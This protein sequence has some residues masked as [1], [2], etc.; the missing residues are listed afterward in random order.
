M[1]RIDTLTGVRGVAALW[2]L[3]HHAATAYLPDRA[4]YQVLAK[5]AA[6]GWLGVD[7][8]FVLSGFVIS[9]VYCAALRRREPGA[10]A[11]FLKLRIARVYPAQVVTTL[12]LVPIY[13]AAAILFRYHSPNDNFSIMKLLYSLTLLNGWGIPNSIGWNNVSWSVS[14][15]WFAYLIFPALAL[16]IGRAKS[17]LIN[18]GCIAAIFAVMFG[19]ALWLNHGEKYMLDPQYTL[20]RVGSEFVVG[21]LLYN[22]FR[23]LPSTVELD[24]MAVPAL[25]GIVAVCAGAVP[26]LA[27]GL[28]VVLFAVLVLALSRPGPVSS[29]LLGTRG[30][31]Y[32]GEIS[33]SIYVLHT[34]VLLVMGQLA[35]RILP[36]SDPARWAFL[37]VYVIAT[38]GCAHAVYRF[39]EEPARAYLRRRWTSNRERRPPKGRSSVE[40]CASGNSEGGKRVQGRA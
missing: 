26:P 21:C 19:L 16:V 9:L 40:L 29:A 4:R 10:T 33:Y 25:A 32:L 7:L 2:V 28:V 8:F 30:A 14:S 12:A 6:R 5:V 11:R 13:V 3:M 15:E 34:T 17:V 18:V 27:D 35:Q 36:P 37:G 24:W 22:I 20:A 23:A 39:V 38:I 1:K 31:V